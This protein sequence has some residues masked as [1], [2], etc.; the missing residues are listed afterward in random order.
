MQTIVVDRGIE[1]FVFCFDGLSKGDH[2]VLVFSAGQ[3]VALPD[4]VELA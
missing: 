2:A 3:W 1:L 4:K